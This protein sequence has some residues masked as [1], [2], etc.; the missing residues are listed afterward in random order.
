MTENVLVRFA[1]SPTGWLHVG[2][3]R[4]AIANFLFAKSLG[5]AVA[6]MDNGRVVHS[7]AMAA[8][9]EDRGLQQRL[10]GLSLDQHQ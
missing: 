1:P 3:V 10:L 5:D 7:G 8:L 9:A 2:N 6:V 4:T